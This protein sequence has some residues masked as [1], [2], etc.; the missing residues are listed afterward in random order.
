MEINQIL[1]IIVLF[2]GVDY[3]QKRNLHILLFIIVLAFF[4]WS[5]IKPAYFPTWV[6]EVLPALVAIAVT[7]FLYKRFPLTTLSYT[8]IAFV[9]ILM[10][11]G[12]HYIYAN[13][14]LFDWL[15]DHFNLKRNHYDRFGH[16]M[17]G[18]IVII[19]REILMRKTPLSKGALLN[20]LALSVTLSIAA[21][22]EIIEWLFANLTGGGK[23]AH[24]F[25]GAQGDFWDTQWD[26]FLTFSGALL[27]LLLFTKMHN[28]L[29]ERE[30]G[31]K[32]KEVYE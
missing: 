29:L 7:A 13:V 31:I 25:L 28:S 3:L 9:T 19:F 17:K 18:L 2:I 22:Y 15:K 6:A 27:S 20:W 1:Y 21:L 11:I 30:I 32:Q 12:G 16:L 14:P 23:A 10:F 26:M 5:A 4:T 8:I 24:D